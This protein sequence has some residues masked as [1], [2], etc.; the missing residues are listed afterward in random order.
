M[1][2]LAA[3]GPEGDPTI[4]SRILADRSAVAHRSGDFDGA[5]TY[6]AE[7][8]VIATAAGDPSGVAQAEDLLGIVARGRGD[9]VDARLHLERA[10]AAVDRA[11]AT[12]GPDAV[13]DPGVRV[14]A[15][16]T[17][18]LISADEGDR[19]RAMAL[20][21]EAL[22]RCELQGDRHRQAALENNLADLLQATGRAD[23]AMAHLK[24]AVALFA[25]VGGRPGGLEPEIWKLV[26]W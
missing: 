8:L 5:Q 4:A 22:A 25:E 19:D 3:V 7:A 9:L 11:E 17:L 1:A 24:R 26:E 16:N 15:L 10:V 12:A 18:A 6:A 21:R 2:A 13:I 14:A 23:E 20:T